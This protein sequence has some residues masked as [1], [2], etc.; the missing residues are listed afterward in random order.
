MK[1]CKKISYHDHTEAVKALH[2]ICNR[3]GDNV[4]PCR[5]YQCDNCGKWHLTSKPIDL[6][7]GGE[8]RLKFVNSW[9]ALL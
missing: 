2:E 4:K 1:S 6:P 3:K 8:F 7:L 9:R 5:A